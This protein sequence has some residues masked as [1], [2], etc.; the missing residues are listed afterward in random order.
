MFVCT[1]VDNVCPKNRHPL[2]GGEVGIHS[3]Y[4]LDSRNV[5][6]ISHLPLHSEQCQW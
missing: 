4:N 2:S 3:H 5:P 6:P 1:H